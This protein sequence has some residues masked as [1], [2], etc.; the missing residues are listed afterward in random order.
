[1]KEMLEKSAD[2]KVVL[3]QSLFFCPVDLLAVLIGFYCLWL[4]LFQWNWVVSP[5]LSAHHLKPASILH[6]SIPALNP[7]LALQLHNALLKLTKQLALA[8]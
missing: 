8:P 7:T 4:Q 3:S 2:L 6:A 1:M 5:M